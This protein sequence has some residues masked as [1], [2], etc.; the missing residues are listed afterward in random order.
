[1]KGLVELKNKIVKVFYLNIFKI[2]I[3][4]I[5][6]LFVIFLLVYIF[7]GDEMLNYYLLLILFVFGIFFILLMILKVIVKR[8]YN[9]RMIGDGGVSIEKEKLVVDIVILLS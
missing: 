5:M 6:G 4:V 9:I 3:W 2:G 1:M 8:V 7:V